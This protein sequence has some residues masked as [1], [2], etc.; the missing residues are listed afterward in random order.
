MAK[1]K[2]KERIVKAAKEKQL[3]TQKGT[4]IKP[5]ANFSVENL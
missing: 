1:N 2:D 3:V 5:S 4:P